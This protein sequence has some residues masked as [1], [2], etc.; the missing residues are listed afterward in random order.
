MVATSKDR[1]LQYSIVPSRDAVAVKDRKTGK[2]VAEVPVGRAPEQILVGPDD[3]VYVTNRGSRSVSVIARGAW[4]EAARLSVGVEPVGL[5]VSPDNK[6]LYVVNSASLESAD[7]GT[8]TAVDLQSGEARWEIPV[9][10][11]PRR[12]ELHG[13][14]AEVVSRGG[15]K[16]KVDLQKSR[17]PRR[18]RR[19]APVRAPSSGSTARAQRS[20]R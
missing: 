20:P 9:G 3:K 6:T 5:A 4:K 15:Q 10:E 16:V 11:E 1:V 2:K 12:V 19:I 7:A 18:S 14:T 13:T 8:L 17:S